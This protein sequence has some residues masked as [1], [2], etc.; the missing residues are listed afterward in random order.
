[1]ESLCCLTG[2]GI[3]DVRQNHWTECLYWRAEY[4]SQNPCHTLWA[5]RGSCMG[6]AGQI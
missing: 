3:R 6:P 4:M 2:V 5:V 1:M